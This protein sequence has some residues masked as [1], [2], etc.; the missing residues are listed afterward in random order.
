M[1]IT[2]KVQNWSYSDKL[3]RIK[4]PVGISYNSDVEK[5]MALCLEAAGA[6]PRVFKQPAPRCLIKGF[7]DSSVDLDVRVWIDDPQEG[8][9]NVTSDVYLNIWKKF[10][11]HGIEIPFPQRDVHLKA[12]AVI[13]VRQATN[14]DPEPDPDPDPGP[15]GEAPKASAKTS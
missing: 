12:P 8:R 1:L 2:E 6:T 13:E 11:E 4:I 15:D 14:P 7:G 9:A 5:A 10:H 3:V